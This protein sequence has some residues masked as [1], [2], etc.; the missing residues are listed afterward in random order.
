MKIASYITQPGVEFR[1][2]Q[3]ETEPDYI[4]CLAHV[5]RSPTSGTIDHTDTTIPLAIRVSARNPHIPDEEEEELTELRSIYKDEERKYLRHAAAIIPATN[6]AF[7]AVYPFSRGLSK[8][9]NGS[10]DDCARS[11]WYYPP[12][13]T[14][15]SDGIHVGTLEDGWV[16]PRPEKYDV[17]KDEPAR[18]APYE[19][20]QGSHPSGA[21]YTNVRIVITYSAGAL[22]DLHFQSTGRF[23]DDVNEF[24]R[25][26]VPWE[27]AVPGEK[28]SVDVLVCCGGYYW[29]RGDDGKTPVFRLSNTLRLFVPS[30]SFVS[31][32]T[33]TEQKNAFTL[34]SEAQLA[35]TIFTAYMFTPESRTG[36]PLGSSV[37]ALKSR[38]STIVVCGGC[39]VTWQYSKDSPDERYWFTRDTAELRDSTYPAVMIRLAAHVTKYTTTSEVGPTH[40]VYRLVVE[41][42]GK[43]WKLYGRKENTAINICTDRMLDNDREVS[44]ERNWAPVLYPT[45]LEVGSRL[46]S[47]GG[48]FYSVTSPRADITVAWPTE[49]QTSP[50]LGPNHFYHCMM[51][52]REKNHAFNVPLLS[53]QYALVRI[54]YPDQST[55]WKPLNI[56]GEHGIAEGAVPIPYPADEKVILVGGACTNAS[57]V[58]GGYQD[59]G[60]GAKKYAHNLQKFSDVRI[61]TSPTYT[62][63]RIRSIPL[64]SKIIPVISP[65]G[66]YRS[67][68][69]GIDTLK[70][71]CL[72]SPAIQLGSSDYFV[73]PF[74]KME[75]TNPSPEYSTNATLIR[76]RKTR[77]LPPDEVRGDDVKAHWDAYARM[78][79]SEVVGMPVRHIDKTDEDTPYSYQNSLPARGSIGAITVEENKEY[80]VYDLGRGT[81]DAQYYHI[82]IVTTA[83]SLLPHDG[84]SGSTRLNQ[85][86]PVIQFG[87]TLPYPTKWDGGQ[88]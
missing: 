71:D 52:E 22:E 37:I 36:F 25:Q 29:D 59:W 83:K 48:D 9:D 57:A 5:V 41:M 8:T 53:C 2:D 43:H 21:S 46:I 47:Y 61:R 17:D 82:K 74:T 67:F 77:S 62:A 69:L 54:N 50:I 24:L 31:D 40:T 6:G 88:T 4:Q 76:R 1:E 14:K 32:S 85:G 45:L 20:L 60:P 55:I 23:S 73:L 19:S 65:V 35:Q 66:E 42:R 18:V 11:V 70:Y 87:K 51:H 80:W 49:S 28:T 30:T 26:F 78:F 7:W 56:G 16:R 33:L 44:L 84:L 86:A 39:R 63:S 3:Y 72:Y 13:A 27:R 38:P 15:E 81:R 58:C 79:V 12:N 75:Y 64:Y 68:E 34:D 10:Y